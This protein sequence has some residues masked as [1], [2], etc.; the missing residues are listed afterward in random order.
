VR[1]IEQFGGEDRFRCCQLCQRWTES[2]VLES[3]KVPDPLDP[4]LKLDLLLCA[5]C[6]ERT[7]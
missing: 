7:P 6:R 3:T 2:M 4:S 1:T 5:T